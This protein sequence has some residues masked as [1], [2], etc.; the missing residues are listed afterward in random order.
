[1]RRPKGICKREMSVHPTL[2]NFHQKPSTSKVGKIGTWV[3]SE[4][5]CM[6]CRPSSAAKHSSAK[7]VARYCCRLRSPPIPNWLTDWHLSILSFP[8][9]QM[10]NSLNVIEMEYSCLVLYLYWAQSRIW[11]VEPHAKRKSNSMSLSNPLLINSG[12]LSR[13]A[14]VVENE[15]APIVIAWGHFLAFEHLF[16]KA[17]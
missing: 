10:F 16:Q 13:R 8:L 1:M 4:F 5:W 15:L 12:F 2:I 6:L 14:K 11:Y 3:V 17:Y 7:P 9:M